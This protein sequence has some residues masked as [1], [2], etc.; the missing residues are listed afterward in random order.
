MY[1]IGEGSRFL[2]V[3]PVAVCAVSG[4]LIVRFRLWDQ[5]GNLIAVTSLAL[6]VSAAVVALNAWLPVT[7]KVDASELSFERM[8]RVQAR[9]RKDRVRSVVIV[10]G[11]LTVS[12]RHGESLI[13]PI[14]LARI[15]LHQLEAL[16]KAV[17]S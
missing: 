10:Q 17:E 3:G 15:N 2:S 16:K 1:R 12:G 9:V 7:A 6:I 8:R 13:T 4:A 5:I 11:C 14:A